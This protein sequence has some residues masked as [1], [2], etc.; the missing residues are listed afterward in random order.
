MEIHSLQFKLKHKEYIYLYTR[1]SNEP[2]SCPV[3]PGFRTHDLLIRYLIT[4][5]WRPVL[6]QLG[7]HPTLKKVG[8]M[9]QLYWV[10]L[11]LTSHHT[12][13]WSCRIYI[14]RYDL[15]ETLQWSKMLYSWILQYCIIKICI[16][17][18][19]TC[20]FNIT[21]LHS[22]Y[23]SYITV[24]PLACGSSVMFRTGCP[25]KLITAWV[26]KSYTNAVLW[27]QKPPMTAVI[28]QGH[29]RS[30]DVDH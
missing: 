10:E 6:S 22:G 12:Q 20:N 18:S 9:A 15:R 13:I 19:N 24:M 1:L 14:K 8:S 7:H 25:R 26:I 23:W 3:S 4:K 28:K 30:C 27:E 2:N 29:T 21:P 11:S 16:D 5:Q 17:H